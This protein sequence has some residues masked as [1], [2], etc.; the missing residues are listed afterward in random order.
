MDD[1]ATKNRSLKELE[2]ILQ[3]RKYPKSLIERGINKAKAL[4]Q[5]ELRASRPEQITNNTV[6]LVTT[7]NPNNP[8]IN[9]LIQTDL[10]MLK[11]GLTML[12]T[13]PRL[14]II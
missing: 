3:T 6:T 14:K 13:S 9:S 11:T 10:T 5:D 2:K 4:N 1:H 7:F 12:K 8:S